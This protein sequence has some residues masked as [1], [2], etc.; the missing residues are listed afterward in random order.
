MRI[1]LVE[2]PKAPLTI[3][4][5]DVFLFESLALE[6]LAAAVA[7]DHDVE[8]LDLRL[9]ENLPET[10]ERFRPDVVGITAYTVHV[11]VVHRLF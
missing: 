6:Y 11:N 10:L 2:P 9:G 8:I 3:G 1:L 4:G 7:P 5:E